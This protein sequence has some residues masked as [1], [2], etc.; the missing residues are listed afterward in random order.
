MSGQETKV[1]SG[2]LRYHQRDGLPVLQLQCPGCGRW[3]DI[4]DDQANGRVS[5]DH[6]GDGG[7]NF[8]ETR[9]WLETAEWVTS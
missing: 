6:A 5:V 2:R 4:D 3:G 9:N 1:P 7:C 8:H